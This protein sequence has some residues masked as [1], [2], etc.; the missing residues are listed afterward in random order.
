MRGNTGEAYDG[1]LGIVLEFP[2][3]C[4]NGPPPEGFACEKVLSGG[5]S[6]ESALRWADPQ[7]SASKWRA[8]GARWPSSGWSPCCSS[9]A[10]WR[11]LPLPASSQSAR[12]RAERRSWR[13]PPGLPENERNPQSARW[14]PRSAGLVD[15]DRKRARLPVRRGPWSCRAPRRAAG[16]S[17]PHRR[18]DVAARDEAF[19]AT[20]AERRMEAAV[21]PAGPSTTARAVLARIRAS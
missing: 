15:A 10:V 9:S 17:R 7:R 21:H 16:R 12:E 2:R 11:P 19:E 1:N 3:D 6:C 18:C 14:L 4:R 8:N 5:F 20:V 13:Q